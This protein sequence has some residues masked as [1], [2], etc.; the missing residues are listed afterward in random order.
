M[1]NGSH[2]VLPVMLRKEV[3]E[4]K[5]GWSYLQGLHQSMTLYA[6]F[7]IAIDGPCAARED[8]CAARVQLSDKNSEARS[9]DTA[10]EL[11]TS[12]TNGSPRYSNTLVIIFASPS[13]NDI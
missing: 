4:N 10:I 2:T 7:S 3:R 11:I 9:L 6:R 12:K 1:T 13:R 8:P 5:E